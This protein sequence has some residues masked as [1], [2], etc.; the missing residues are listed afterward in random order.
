MAKIQATMV[1]ALNAQI[2]R[3]LQASQNYL[4]MAVDLD[5]RSLEHLAAFFYLQ[6]DEERAHALKIVRYLLEV[7][8]RPAIPALEQPESAFG[9]L[10][11]IV[12][13]S[14]EQER[15]VTA[16]IHEIADAAVETRDHTTFQFLRWFVDE[17]VEEEA[18]FCK[19]VDIVEMSNNPLQVEQYMR[20]M[21]GAGGGESG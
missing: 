18:T 5:A 6:A 7:G 20:H 4:A 12:R 2:V 10:D 21:M 14:L 1:D 9:S 8:H 13:R 11:F 15:V 19:L 17:Q 16:A 3:E